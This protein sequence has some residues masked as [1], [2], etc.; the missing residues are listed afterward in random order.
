MFA[1]VQ[2]TDSAAILDPDSVVITDS[3]SLSVDSSLTHLS[4]DS[5]Y[6]TTTT[7]SEGFLLSAVEYNAVDS[8]VGSLTIGKAYLY[9]HA[10]VKYEDLVIEAGYIAI[11]FSSKEVKATGIKDSTGKI[12]QKPIFTE[13]GKS[14]RAD[15]MRY[16]FSSKKAKIK[17]VITKE[18]EGF[19]HGEEVKKV[20]EKTFFIRNASYTTCSHEHPHFAINTP[21]AKMIAGDKIVT[22]FAYLSIMDIPTP[23]M[24][25][26]G[27][28]P[29]TQSR[30]SG[31]IIPTYGKNEYRGFFLTNGGYY[32][33]IN[34][35]FDLT[36]TAD[37]YTQ[38]GYGL[39]LQSNYAKRYKYNGSL[40]ASYN[41]IKFGDAS[42]VD[43]AGE[44]FDDRSDYALTWRHNQDPKA[45]PD[46]KFSGNVNLAS[47][48]FYKV[49]S[50]NTQ[51]VLQNR[52]NSSVSITKNFTNRPFNLT[53]SA[54]HSQNNQTEALTVT[55]PE[56]NFFV[57]RQFPFK[58]SKRVGKKKWYE[59]IGYSYNVT[60]KN[61]IKSKL[62]KPFFTE[63][64]FRDSA[65]NGIRHSIPVS[66]NYKIFKYV[67]FNPSVSYTERWYFNR[68]DR[69]YND[70]LNQ[71]VISDT[72][73]GF[74]ANRSFSSTANFSTKL[75]GMWRLKG[76]VRAIRHVATPRVGFSYTP[77]FSTNF[78]GSYYQ[79][80]QTD[81][82][83]NTRKFNRYSN[84]I[85]GSAGEAEQGSL[86]F[87][88]QNTLEAKVKSKKDSSGL[89]KIKLLERLSLNTSYNIAAEEYKWAPLQL[90]AASSILKGF[91]NLNYSARYDF[92]GFDKTTNKRVPEF[93]YKVNDKWARLTSQ[94]FA[95][96]TTITP[97]RFKRKKGKEKSEA[98][99]TENLGQKKEG[100]SVPEEQITNSVG[101]TD[102]DI[103]YYLPY[104]YVD[105][106]APWSL[107]LN[108]NLTK[109]TSGIN[110]N[111]SQSADVSGNIE[112][113]E[114]LRVGF[115]T[116]YDLVANEVTYTSFDFYRNLHCWEIRCSWVPFG[117]Q[118]SI[119]IGIRVKASTLS[120][121]KLERVRGVGDYQ[122]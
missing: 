90:T 39:K 3:T 102:G 33:A 14:Y 72:T 9:N 109:N 59:E 111:V 52:L 60:G 78:M 48:S 25:P 21:K 64:V 32:W 105:F 73:N 83:G 108:Y 62:N 114:N 122:R 12:T 118:Q 23:L 81:T 6:Q 37:G 18:G 71:V 88:L 77:D 10:Y 103:N 92:Y 101:V 17:K 51:D 95:A 46:F 100:A 4:P 55:L 8:I 5:V 75:Y 84:G 42:F 61:E 30:K 45:R 110:T 116:G 19:L 80:L 36:A 24:V 11:D 98:E 99:R 50:T 2:P 31:I 70:S 38:G 66:A 13:N 121:L 86:N 7:D 58:R 47:S 112:L 63:T 117:F 27:F 40:S 15:E 1:Q 82:L 107:N 16:N 53:V 96:S 79:T 91:L 106:E 93:A 56:A 119:N 115:S 89:Q 22:R 49:T 68:Y 29:T 97:D 34:D 54:N 35:Y 120:D 44:Y 65:R 57:D 104:N 69:A 85:Y 87:G 113:T 74:F 94:N 67:V 28:F 41:R 20:D 76:P 43:F 26:F